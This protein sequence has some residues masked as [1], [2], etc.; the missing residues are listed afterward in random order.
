MG[1][2]RLPSTANSTIEVPVS[3]DS[4]KPQASSHGHRSGRSS[5]VMVGGARMNPQWMGVSPAIIAALRRPGR[6]LL[7][8]SVVGF[9]NGVSGQTGAPRVQRLSSAERLRLRAVV[10]SCHLAQRR[11]SAT[12]GQLSAKVALDMIRVR[13]IL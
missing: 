11:S 4:L 6:G 3:T 7:E 1:L 10:L 9:S 5:A 13:C 2:G 8:C 12:A